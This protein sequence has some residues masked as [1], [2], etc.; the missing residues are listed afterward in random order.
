MLVKRFIVNIRKVVT[1]LRHDGFNALF[2]LLYYKLA[3]AI[4]RRIGNIKQKLSLAT[5]RG[6]GMERPKLVIFTGV[7]F[8]DI[9]GGQRSAQLTR[10]A[11]KTGGQVLYVYGYPK[12]DFSKRRNVISKVTFPN[13]LHKHIKEL[14]VKEFL[15]FIGDNSTV[16]F[17]MPH[18]LFVEYLEIACTRGVRTVFE[19]IDDWSTSLGGD[20]F[21]QEV[22]EKFVLRAEVVTGTSRLL[23]TQLND[24]GRSDAVYL[25][26][27][28]NEYIFDKNATYTRPSDLPDSSVALYMGSLYGEWFGWVYIKEAAKENPHINFCLIGNKPADLP[29]QFPDNVHFLGEKKIEEL[30]FYLSS[31]DFCLLPFKPSALT[32]AVSP[33][34]VF[35]YLFMA[36]PIVSTNMTE[37]VEYP[38][39]F[40]AQ[41][42]SEYASLCQNVHRD[43]N[44]E[45]IN[46]SVIDEFIF[47]N[48]WFSRLQKIVEIKGQQNVSAIILIH[49]NR[50]IIGRCLQSLVDNC[51]SYLS[52]VIVVDNIS[53]DGGGDYVM[54]NFPQVR[55]VRNSRNGCSS[56]RNLGVK[57]SSGKYLAFFDSDQWFTSGFG[58]EEALNI[59]EAHGEIGA[60]GWSAGWLNLNQEKLTDTIADYHAYRAVN[61]RAWRIGY[62]TDVSYLGSDGLFVPRTVF[63]ATGG[64]DEA[65]DPM[66]FGDTDL[67]FAIKNLG[68]EVAYRDLSCIRHQP[69]QTTKASDS[70]LEY[71][72]LYSRNSKYFLEKWK[73]H[74]HLFVK[75]KV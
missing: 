18:P 56:G 64:F 48:S 29:I 28:A 8:D 39:V 74:R 16:V 65:Y 70:S 25:P 60:V 15:K 49:N 22:F 37:V 72:K 7:P 63:E 51:S 59:L 71:Q 21:R 3:V 75:H 42:E 6:Q 32:D 43:N 41:N 58:F 35:E 27:A 40:T 52:E 31:A 34:K 53:E 62:R 46:Q 61:S 1:V 26:N 20:W 23:V 36:K 19:L 54:E 66:S 67:S 69:H 10:A 50:N 11:L 17:E 68:F 12:Y 9:G 73:D 2:R 14:S 44:P 38:Y 30:P 47:R 57:N 4:D 55:L 13:I 33:I 5:Q 24:M 45:N